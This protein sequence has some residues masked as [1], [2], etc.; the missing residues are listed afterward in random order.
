MQNPSLTPTN[1]LIG[2]LSALQWPVVVIAAFAL[3]RSMSKLESRVLKAEK[4]LSDLMERHLP[5]I[6]NALAEIRG[7]L[8]KGRC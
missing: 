1:Y 3:G 7:L 5:H 8:L 2:V 4:S 6:H